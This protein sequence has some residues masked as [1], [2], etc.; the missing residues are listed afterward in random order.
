MR[1]LAIFG[2]ILSI[3]P[4]TATGQERPTF[5]SL[6]KSATNAPSHRTTEGEI[7]VVVEVPNEHAIYYFTKPGEPIHPGVIKRTIV[8]NKSG[9]SLQTQGWSFAPEGAQEPFKKWLAEFEAQGA[10]I[11]ARMRQQQTEGPHKP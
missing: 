10:E 9:I 2:L 3:M 4:L 1:L 6:W 8:E 11:Q 7:A 5:D